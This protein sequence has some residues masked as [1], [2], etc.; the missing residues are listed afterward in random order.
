MQCKKTLPQ[1]YPQTSVSK[2][3]LISTQFYFINLYSAYW[4]YAN[5]RRMQ[6]K[7]DLMHGLMHTKQREF[8]FVSSFV[9]LLPYASTYVLMLVIMSLYMTQAWLHSFVLPF[10]CPYVYAASV[11]QALMMPKYHWTTDLQQLKTVIILCMYI[12]TNSIKFKFKFKFKFNPRRISLDTLRLFYLYSE[13]FFILS[14]G[15][16][17]I[18]L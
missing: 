16:I 15:I 7:K 14:P 1:Q 4:R 12:V 11:S 2:A 10:V 6:T 3:K 18:V 5:Q 9:L 8:F 17:S 13:C